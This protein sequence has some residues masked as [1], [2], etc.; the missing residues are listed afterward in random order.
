MLESDAQP[1]ESFLRVIVSFL[2]YLAGQIASLRYCP[3]MLPGFRTTHA[4]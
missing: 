1:L 2:D 3:L 4:I